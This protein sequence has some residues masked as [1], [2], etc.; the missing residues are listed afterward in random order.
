MSALKG[1]D[2]MAWVL[3]IIAI[4][5]GAYIGYLWDRDFRKIVS[6]EYEVWQEKVREISTKH[7]EWVAKQ[8]K[9]NPKQAE[10]LVP[11]VGKPQI[12]PQ[13]DH[14][15]YPFAWV[16]AM[17]GLFISGPI[18]FVVVLFSVRGTIHGTI[19]FY[20]WIDRELENIISKVNLNQ[21][22]IIGISVGLIF[23]I[24]TYAIAQNLA[25]GRAFYFGKTWF[26][27]IIFVTIVGYFE[28]KLFS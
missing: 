15:K 1:F 18:F 25:W 13:P 22:V 7:D 26:V 28:Y 10:I 21:K 14:W 8:Y 3:A 4:L 16:S 12:P 11:A 17:A 9:E 24:I 20:K 27:W 5:P 2:R 23:F 19:H 6:P